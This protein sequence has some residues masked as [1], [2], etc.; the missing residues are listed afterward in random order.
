MLQEEEHKSVLWLTLLGPTLSIF[1]AR[2]LS[3]ATKETF[4]RCMSYFVLNI[5]RQPFLVVFLG[6]K[7]FCWKTFSSL[8]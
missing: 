4:P 3:Q 6:R 1:Y 5:L 7:F 8:Q 2:D